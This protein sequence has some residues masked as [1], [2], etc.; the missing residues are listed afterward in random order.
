MQHQ[1]QNVSI[2]QINISNKFIH[3]FLT[4]LSWIIFL[5]LC[6][7]TCSYIT[8]TLSRLFLE[9]SKA[10]L[11]WH[12]MDLDS[13]YTLNESSFV[14]ISSLIIIVALLKTLLFYLIVRI[15]YRKKLSLSK[16]FNMETGRF[17]FG[18]GY[19]TLAIGLFSS[20]GAE[21]VMGLISQ[22]IKMPLLEQL[23]LSGADVWLFMSITLFVIAHIFKRGIALQTE[24]E[25]TI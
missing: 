17:L 15:L 20:W 22:G 14:V 24:N 16:P 5:G 13:L 6:I 11:M 18:I 2:M 25:F 9:P 8:S 7:E 19:T 21:H 4:V 12:P 1:L 10:Q 3:Q 23:N